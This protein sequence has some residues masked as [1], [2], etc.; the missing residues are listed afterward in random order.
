MDVS[1]KSVSSTAKIVCHLC[2]I[3]STFLA[4]GI[5]NVS[6]IKLNHVT[7]NLRSDRREP[8]VQHVGT[9]FVKRGNG[10]VDPRT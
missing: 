3:F 1:E 4:Y 10:G 8:K 5:T 7:Y 9:K 6:K 2:Q